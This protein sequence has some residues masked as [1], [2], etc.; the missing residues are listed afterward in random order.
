MDIRHLCMDGIESMFSFLSVPTTPSAL[1]RK[2]ST[3]DNSGPYAPCKE[4]LALGFLSNQVDGIGSMFVTH[5]SL[6]DR[7]PEELRIGCRRKKCV[8]LA[9]VAN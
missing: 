5:C 3:D 9:T 6:F 1:P 8:E 7:R 2:G 4:Y